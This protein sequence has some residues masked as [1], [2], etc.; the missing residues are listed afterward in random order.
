M[1][2]EGGLLRLLLRPSLEHSS[3]RLQGRRDAAALDMQPKARIVSAKL[4][5]FDPSML[6]KG[7]GT[8][9]AFPRHSLDVESITLLR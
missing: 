1:P 4:S 5:D 3:I 8:R 2:V 7:F 6:P 9:W